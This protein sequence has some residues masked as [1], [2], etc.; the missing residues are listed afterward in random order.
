MNKK[1]LFVIE[2]KTMCLFPWTHM[3]I[4]TT[5]DVYPCCIAEPGDRHLSLGNVKKQTIEEIWNGDAYKTLRKNMV[6][7]I[8]SPNCNQCY[9]REQSEGRNYRHGSFNM[10]RKDVPTL[11]KT[12]AP[13]YSLSTVDIKYLDIRF[14]NL[15]SFKCRYCSEQF[16]TSWA[17]ENRKRDKRITS[18]GLLHVSDENPS[19]LMS[20]KKHLHGIEHMYFAGGEPLMTEEHYEILDTLI[21]YGKT[22]V[23][24]RYSSNCSTLTFKDYDV[25]NLWSKFS[26]VDFRASLDSFGQRAEYMRKGTDWPTIVKNI[27]TIKAQ[28]PNV[29]VSINCVVSAYNILTLP[30]FVENLIENDIL[31]L[32]KTMVVLYPISG[33]YWADVNILPVKLKKEAKQKLE[34]CIA[35]QPK[36]SRIYHDLTIITNYINLEEPNQEL[37]S[38]FK[39]FN[40]DLDVVRDEKFTDIFPEL[41]EWY[42]SI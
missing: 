21:K 39:Q 38:Q 40:D 9:I 35:D 14:S 24:L 31:E 17:A 18:P 30:E 8:Q 3:Y 13:D 23:K 16:S 26:S 34:K 19:F 6:E 22:D 5:G 37:W 10:F 2:N 11:I 15:C 42:Q 27:Q 28:A 1:E 36:N 12:T 41:A 29:E 20:V 7:G 32:S 33:S 4:H 25:T